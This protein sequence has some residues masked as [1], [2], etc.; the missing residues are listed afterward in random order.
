MTKPEGP[1][2]L[3]AA[4]Q[5]FE[6]AQVERLEAMNDEELDEAL[7]AEGLEPKRPAAGA[8]NAEK[9]PP[10]P[11]PIAP[12][13]SKRRPQWI[14]WAAAAALAVAAI[15]ALAL[16]SLGGGRAPEAQVDPKNPS[17]D[18]LARAEK[19]R[20]DAARACAQGLWGSCAQK[21]DEAT[22][23]DA[24]GEDAERVVHLRA[25]LRSVPRGQ[26]GGDAPREWEAKPPRR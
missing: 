4:I 14:V 2:G 6:E 22:A 5:I 7:L 23:L 16:P 1:R 3:E 24:A 18:A 8:H 13:A 21:L 17:A 11:V 10:R 26:Q 20:D 15:A 12:R 25:V 19:L 9:A